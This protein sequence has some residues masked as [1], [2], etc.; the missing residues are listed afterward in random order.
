[1]VMTV[2]HQRLGDLLGGAAVGGV[3]DGR[4]SGAST[5]PASRRPGVA[6]MAK[7]LGT[8]K[9]RAKPS[10]TS[11][12]S[13]FLPTPSTSERRSTFIDSSPPRPRRRLVVRS[14]RRRPCV[15]RRSASRRPRAAGVATRS[16]RRPRSPRSPRRRGR[17]TVTA[18]AALGRDPVGVGQQRHLAG[19]LDRP[20]DLLLLLGVVAGHPAGAD[21]GPVG[22]EPAE[23]VDVLVVDV[24]DP[25][26]G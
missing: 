10:A 13:P 4:A 7:P 26:P 25:A 23:Q 2:G 3:L 1:M 14:P 11:T 21:L 17:A 5:S 6:L 19:V 24:L 12:M 16:R 9:L 20:G 18:A 8:R 15:E 22:H